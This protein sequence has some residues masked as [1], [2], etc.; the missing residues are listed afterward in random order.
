MA[1]HDG[2]EDS[3]ESWT[4]AQP[5]AA[6]SQSS[7]SSHLSDLQRHLEKQ[8]QSL[9]ALMREWDDLINFVEQFPRKYIPRTALAAKLGALRPF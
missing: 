8:Q 5:A 6:T 9:I 7:S 4:L 1:A 3:K 2:T